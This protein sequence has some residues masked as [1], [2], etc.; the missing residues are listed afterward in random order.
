M[1][2]L[3]GRVVSVVL[4][5]L[6]VFAAARPAHAD[7]RR[8]WIIAGILYGL[9]A[10]GSGLL[11]YGTYQIEA[12]PN[13]RTLGLYHA[14]ANSGEVEQGVGGAAMGLFGVAATMSIIIGGIQPQRPRPRVQL[15]PTGNGLAIGGA[16]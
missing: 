12:A 8:R 7:N 1:A 5:F 2:K 3:R 4:A 13:A 16:F 15:V 6:I 11:A 9:S 14:A 10:V